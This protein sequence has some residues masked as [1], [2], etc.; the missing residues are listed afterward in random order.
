M[1]SSA[2]S[3]EFSKLSFQTALPRLLAEIAARLGVPRTSDPADVAPMRNV[4]PLRTPNKV[5]YV[6]KYF[7]ARAQH[8]FGI[9]HDAETAA[10]LADMILVKFAYL[11]QHPKM[12]TLTEDSLNFTLEQA[13]R[14][15]DNEHEINS[16]L[17]QFLASLD[18]S[19]L[20]RRT[21]KQ[22]NT[23]RAEFHAVKEEIINHITEQISRL[24]TRLDTIEK[25]LCNRSGA[26]GSLPYFGDSMPPQ[27]AYGG[28]LPISS[29]FGE[30]VFSDTGCVNEPANGNVSE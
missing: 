28:D 9:F 24:S 26:A 18:E 29:I 12:K 21:P 30:K 14:D 7:I 4:Y 8:T 17:T 20:Q 16:L 27:S 23:A 15:L 19:L 2:Y 6:V 1:I 13:Q 11:R 25:A 5:R 22:R 3:A 10:R